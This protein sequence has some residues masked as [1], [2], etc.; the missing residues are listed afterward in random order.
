MNMKTGLFLPGFRDTLSL[1]P[2]VVPNLLES[3]IFFAPGPAGFF[4]R[5]VYYAKKL[6]HMGEGVLIDL[7]VYIQNPKVVS[8]GDYTLLSNYVTIE[9]CNGVTIGKRVHVAAYSLIQGLGTVEIGDYAGIGAGSRIYSGTET[10]EGGKRMSGPMVP[11]EQRNVKLGSVVIGK[12][13]FLGVG[14]VVM[15]GV[16]IGEGAIVG[17]GALVLKDIPPWTIAVGVPAKPIKTRPPIS[18]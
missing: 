7:G 2:Q 8:I 14:T 12:D 16:E 18:L 13:A 15:P 1:L 3:W 5:R 17:A 4:L 9:G 11:L 10:F 6:K